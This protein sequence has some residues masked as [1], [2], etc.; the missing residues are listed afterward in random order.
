MGS[1]VPITRDV[2][3]T[4]KQI[5]RASLRQLLWVHMTLMSLIVLVLVHNSYKITSI[6]S[7]VIELDTR[8]VVQLDIHIDVSTSQ[9]E[10]D[11]LQAY[12]DMQ[13]NCIALAIYGEA[14]GETAE[15]MTGVAY[16]I[17]NR[18]LSDNP[19][20]E[21]TPCEVVLQK[22]QFES[23]KGALK[24]MVYATLDGDLQFPYMRNTWL[25][26]KIRGIARDVYYYQIPDPTNFATHFW[27]PKLQ[28]ALGRDKPEWSTRLKRVATLG[29]HIYHE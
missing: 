24:S 4:T 8:H 1:L 18:T 11:L 26:R 16:V 7:K 9:K 29:D 21:D 19:M 5:K 12:D 14:R 27:A 10:L 15:G 23:V 22:Y 25:A 20:F 13:I 2:M 28:Y 17:M 3:M 6:E